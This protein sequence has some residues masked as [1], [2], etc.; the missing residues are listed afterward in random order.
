MR[1]QTQWRVS[2]SGAYGL[3]YTAVAHVFDILGITD[4]EDMLDDLQV[5]EFAIL[6]VMSKTE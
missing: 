4:R 6:R 1:V 3:D 5:M 2:H